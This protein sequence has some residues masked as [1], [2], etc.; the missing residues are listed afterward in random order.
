MT[1]PD[2][3]L[4]VLL[5]GLQKNVKSQQDVEQEKVTSRMQTVPANDW[6]DSWS[7]ERHLL[8][9]EVLLVSVFDSSHRLERMSGLLSGTSSL[10]STTHKTHS[11][12][13]KSHTKKNTGV[14]CLKEQWYPLV[15]DLDLSG[16]LSSMAFHSWSI[17]SCL[18]SAVS[19]AC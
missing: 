9:T 2:L 4:T 11:E 1:W 19:A 15:I 13:Y 17:H 3:R 12:H 18:T 6:N 14:K 16:P 8:S 10:I 7:M 5:K